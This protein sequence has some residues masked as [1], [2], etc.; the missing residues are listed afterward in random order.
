MIASRSPSA[1]ASRLVVRDV[2]GGEPR[3][4][5]QLVD[6]GAHEVAQ[7]R[8][9]VARAARRRGRGRAARRARARARR[10]A[11]GRR[12]AAPGSGRAGSPQ[13]TSAR[14]SPRSTRSPDVLARSGARAAGSRCSCAPSCAARA[15]R[16]GRPC[17]CSACSAADVDPGVPRRRPRRSPNA[18]RPSSAVSSPAMQRSVVVLPQPLGPSSTRNSPGSIVEVEV[19]DRDRRRLARRSAW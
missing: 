2:D 8:V 11:A 17:R 12:S 4:L 9:E 3:L 1:S 6:L 15:R 13:S 14:R 16:T 7:P 10:A 19:V 5:V 18:M